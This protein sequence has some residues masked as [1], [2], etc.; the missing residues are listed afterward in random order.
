MD[1]PGPA[2]G[3]GRRQDPTAGP[4]V[5][6]HYQD[7]RQ[8]ALCS[9][10]GAVGSGHNALPG[11]LHRHHLWVHPQDHGWVQE[12]GKY[13][14]EVPSTSPDLVGLRISEGGLGTGKSLGGSWDLHWREGVG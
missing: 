12:E 2:D 11:H 6:E 7:H 14:F 8:G 13:C 1:P 3:P 5:S 10:A 4:T 9:R